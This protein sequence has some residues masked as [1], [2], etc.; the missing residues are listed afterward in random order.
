MLE[1]AAGCLETAGQGLLRNCNGVLRSQKSLEPHFWKQQTCEASWRFISCYIDKARRSSPYSRGAIQHAHDPFL[2]FLYPDK[3]IL[4]VGSWVAKK[5]KEN[6]H[7]G[8]RRAM[9]RL[10]KHNSSQASCFLSWRRDTV[11]RLNVPRSLRA[12]HTAKATVDRPA[13]RQRVLNTLFDE[14]RH[15]DYDRM[16]EL[17]KN[18]TQEPGLRSRLVASL[19]QSERSL[20]VDRAVSLFKMIDHHQRTVGDYESI[21][22]SLLRA[23]H[24]STVELL[25]D[26]A[27]A[28]GPTIDAY[29]IAFTISIIEMRWGDVLHLWRRSHDKLGRSLSSLAESGDLPDQVLSLLEYA[30]K[31]TDLTGDS[32]DAQLLSSLLEVVL[33]SN[34]IM[35]HIKVETI[36]SLTREFNDIGLL[37]E[38]HYVQGI[39][40]LIKIGTRFSMVAALVVYRNFRWHLSSAIPP[41][42]L[43]YQLLETLGSL[44]THHGVQYL[45]DEFVRF[46][47]K[48]SVEAY[49]LALTAYSRSGD[50]PKT[51][52]TFEKLLNHYGRPSPRLFKYP[53]YPKIP[54]SIRWVVPV[55]SVYARVG[56]YAAAETEFYKITPIFRLKANNACWNVLISAHANSRRIKQAFRVFRRMQKKGSSPDSYTFAILMGLCAKSGDIEGTMALCQMAEKSNQMH[57][58]LIHAVV[59][60]YCHNQNLEMAEQ[61][62]ESSLSSALAGSSTGIWNRLLWAHAFRAD[63]DSVLRIHERMKEYGIQFN[64]MTYAALMLSFSIV[65]QPASARRL[66]RAL[67]RSRRMHATEFHYTTL[68][69]GFVKKGNRDMAHVIYKEMEERFENPGLSARLLMLRSGLARD[70]VQ[71]FGRDDNGPDYRLSASEDLLFKSIFDF[72]R[73]E[74]ARK[75]PHPGTSGLPY[76]EAFPSLYYEPIL[77]AYSSDGIHRRSKELLDE[78]MRGIQSATSAGQSKVVPSLRFLAVLMEVFLQAGNLETVHLCWELVL[79]RASELTRKLNVTGLTESDFSQPQSDILQVPLESKDKKATKNRHVTVGTDYM[80]P[81]I[82][83]SEQFTLSRHFSLYMRAKGEAQQTSELPK[84]IEDYESRGY[85]MTSGNWLTYI[86]TLAASPRVSEQLSAFATFERIFMPSFPGW[87]RL[88]RGVQLRPQ[89]TPDSLNLLDYRPFGSNPET[90]GKAASRLWGKVDPTWMQPTYNIMVYLAASLKEF[91]HRSL[92]EGSEVLDPL[93]EV[94]PQTMQ[95]LIDMPHLREKFQGVLLRDRVEQVDAGKEGRD[96]YVWTG[97]VLG[98]GGK[99]RPHL[100]T[101]IEHAEYEAAESE[102]KTDPGQSYQSLAQD[103]SPQARLAEDD[104]SND[105]DIDQTERLMLPEDEHNIEI[106]T[107]L[108]SRRRE[109]GIDPVKDEQERDRGE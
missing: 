75:Y 57:A 6:V 23:G 28:K 107:S 61:V 11:V 33:K 35:Q 55:L 53:E 99:R 92:S 48:P 51:K 72:D 98:V 69:Y 62:A 83:P 20:D 39:E 34:T 27:L 66:L 74:Y 106:E 93:F 30:R 100:R 12:I 17:W 101:A 84:L 56:D 13:T 78:Y 44:E 89:G 95:A 1:R 5:K 29:G 42:K 64:E 38:L 19:S 31:H 45:L 32:M 25:C 67:Q 105:G 76:R 52:E 94:A 47:E 96:R 82:I 91:R 79:E 18:S 4:A 24:L 2:D 8:K 80:Q 77:K 87:H 21:F 15:K 68:L 3:C 60:V 50:V 90:L 88:R 22:D 63:L 109:R 10:T 49:M 36:L 102:L 58:S 37:T 9:S 73:R 70:T 54:R 108:E 97:G 81:T 86:R 43:L 7:H 65:G 85:A 41:T 14:T 46:H 16:W 26:D 103:L 40:T 71:V 59:D 104:H